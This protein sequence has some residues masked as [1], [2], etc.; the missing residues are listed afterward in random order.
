MT[1]GLDS[2][3]FY[4]QDFTSLHTFTY[5]TVEALRIKSSLVHYW[6]ENSK[7]NFTGFIRNNAVGQNPHYRVKDDY[8]PWSGSGNPLLAHGEIN[9]NSFQSYGGVIQHQEKFKYM[10]A[11]WISGASID[12]SPNDYYAKYIEINKNANGLYTN[13][14]TN[15]SLLADYQVGLINS[16]VYTQL[17]ITPIKNLKITGAL[18][19]DRIDYEFDNNLDSTAFS[20]VSDGTSNFNY[21]TPKLG[22]TYNFNTSTGMYA[23]YSI[24]FAPPEVSELFRGVTVP[25]LKPSTFSNYEV[26][27]WISFLKNKAQLEVNLYR[28]DGENEIIS[29]QQNDGST[30]KENAGKTQHQGIEYTLN[31][32]PIQDLAI[33]FSGA[34]A[35]HTFIDFIEEGN[36]YNGNK[37]STA[38]EFIANSEITYLPRFFKGF[39]I[40]VEWQRLGKYYLDNNNTE[41]YDGFNLINLRMAYAYKSFDFWINTLNLTNENYATVVSKS[42]W[43]KSYRSGNPRTFNVGIGYKFAK[44]KK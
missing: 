32:K 42:K 14:S 16:A 24:G 5:R 28:L 39:R 41:E 15:D 20:G 17:Q 4:D 2:A 29:V 31:Y 8:R 33:R 18:R 9:L 36:N 40:A 3:N 44:Q 38:P 22:A 11:K 43:G 7:T 35:T 19:Y 13:Y 12:Y 26:G 27:G 23:N 10:K 30:E 21:V 34:N 1:G 37:M 25:T 6:S